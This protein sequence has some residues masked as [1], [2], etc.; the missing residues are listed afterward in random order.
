MPALDATIWTLWNGAEVSGPGS[1]D[2]VGDEVSV[3]VPSAGADLHV[4][5]SMLD[6]ARVGPRHVALYASSGDVL[7]LD[8]EGLGPFGDLVRASACSLPELTLGLRG[9]G[10]ARG[11]PGPD[12]DRFFAPVLAARRAAERAT[13]PAGRLAAMRA[14][15]LAAEVERVLHELAVARYPDNPAERRA[16]ETVLEDLSAPDPHEL[17][18]SRR[19]RAGSYCCERRRRVCV[20]AGV[21]RSV[22]RGAAAH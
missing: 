15:A 1:V 8:G 2:L 11:F 3:Q 6:G 13:D 17:A 9:L 7:E 16:L 5:L 20:V 4:P 12:H 18:R 19:R 22:S 10:S 14:P 21:D